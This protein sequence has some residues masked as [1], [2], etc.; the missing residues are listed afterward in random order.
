MIQ[1]KYINKKKEKK[2]II[3]AFK[4]TNLC[5]LQIYITSIASV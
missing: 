1:K 5:F 2:K 4:F 3:E